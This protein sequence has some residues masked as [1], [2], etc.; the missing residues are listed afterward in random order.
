MKPLKGFVFL[1]ALFLIAVR[2]SAQAG[3]TVGSPVL[4]A[5]E[6]QLFQWAVTQGGLVV[7]V[8]VVIWSYRRDF[9]RVFQSETQRSQEL[10]MTLQSSTTALTMHAEMMRERAHAE[11]DQIKAFTELAGAVKRCEVAQHLF[12]DRERNSG[13]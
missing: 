1:L 12:E 4:N 11:R 3:T 13:R 10:I 5:T 7:V 9:H 8:L 2:A 6:V